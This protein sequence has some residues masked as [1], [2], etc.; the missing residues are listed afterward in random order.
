MPSAPTEK[1]NE[2]RDVFMPIPRNRDLYTDLY[3]KVYL[4]MYKNLKPMYDEIRDIT[5]YPEKLR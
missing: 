5:G 1:R 4:K 2:T 3:E